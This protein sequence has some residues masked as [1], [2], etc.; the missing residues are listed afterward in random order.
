MIRLELPFI[1]IFF[2]ALFCHEIDS[3][4]RQNSQ[5]LQDTFLLVAFAHKKCSF[6]ESGKIN[7]RL[8]STNERLTIDKYMYIPS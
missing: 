4:T 7:D 3:Y 2:L 8:T 5:Q 6:V 1:C